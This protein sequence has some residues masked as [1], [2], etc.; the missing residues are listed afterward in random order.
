MNNLGTFSK[1]ILDEL[2]QKGYHFLNT[3]FSQDKYP[4]IFP[5]YKKLNEIKIGKIYAVRAFIKL[6]P[7]PIVNIDSGL[8]DIKIIRKSNE[9]YEGEILTKVPLNFPISKGQIIAFK[10]DE[11]LYEN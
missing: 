3:S 7:E 10:K 4:N 6:K 2:N 9:H 5:K 11:I 8:I 1:E